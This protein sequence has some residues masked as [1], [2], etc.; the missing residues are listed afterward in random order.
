[1]HT[2]PKNILG[3][4]LIWVIS[5]LLIYTTACKSTQDL[6]PKEVVSII[7]PIP[8]IESDDSNSDD[9][10][11][12]M[13]LL[14]Q[15]EAAIANYRA[16]A[17]REF[18]I[19]DTELDLRFDYE[20]QAVMGEAILTITPYAK[21]QSILVLDAKDFEPGSIYFSHDG[22]ETSTNY[23]YDYKQLMIYLP[24]PV[25]LSDTFSI[26]V[27]Y[28]A[29]P[30]RN[31]GSDNLAIT[32]TKGL[33]F[34]DPL[35]TVPGKPTMIWTQGETEYN[36]KWFPT[37]DKPNE[38]FTQTIH[39]TVKDNLTTVSN[40]ELIAQK[41]LAD[42]MRQDTWRMDLPHAPYLA[43]LAIGEFDVVKRDLDGLP[44][45]YYVEKGY[46]AGA[47][48]VFKHTPEMIRY[49]EDL[50]QVKYP[51]PKYDQIV[52]RDF[53]SGAMENTTASIFME[54]LRLTEREAIDSEWDYIIAHELFHQWFGDLVTTESWANLTLN[55]A[56]ANYSEYLWNEHKYGDDLAKL[57]LIVETETYFQEAETKQ[58]DLIRFDYSD[59]EDMFDAHS[60]SKGGV[61]LHMLR[62]YLG[63]ELFF[64]GLNLYLTTHAFQSVEVHDLR[65][66]FEK[67]SGE[68][69][70]WFFNQWFLDKGHPELKVSIDYSIPEN[71]L[72]T[73]E[74]TQDLTLSPL[75]KLPFEISWYEGEERKS[76]RF[77]LEKGFQQFA[78]ENEF[79]LTQAYFD[80]G[81]DLLTK[82]KGEFSS[83]HYVRQFR[84]S[85]LGIARYEALDSLVSRVEEDKL[86][87]LL[88]EGLKD[89]FWSIRE[90]TLNIL[91]SNPE[92]ISEGM[93]ESIYTIAD[94]DEKNSVRAGA[95]DVLGSLNADKYY[96]DLSRY[97]NDSSF[98]IV[99]SALMAMNNVSSERLDPDLFE[100]FESETNYR[101]LVPVAEYYLNEDIQGKGDWFRSKL[102]V[103]S[104]EG[105][106]YF[107]GY[108]SEYF[109]SNPEE[110]AEEAKAYLL[111]Q[112]QNNPQ[113]FVR[114]G[115]FQ[116]LLGFADDETLV[117]Q[118]QEI[119]SKETNSQIKNYFQYFLQSFGD[120]N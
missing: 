48:R 20:Q 113:V 67:V 103:L 36:S 78:L 101:V 33:Y 62:N 82:R 73:V 21:A 14:R 31:S 1:M 43:A 69:L 10:L 109:V 80:E 29:F 99:S 25:S 116:G 41:P 9:S 79:P 112:M 118:L 105:L 104:G 83:D 66:A 47:A 23:R 44:I 114:L 7:E 96:P 42:G 94:K 60:Y 17:T 34:I 38:R 51:W 45:N 32:D 22:E 61:I 117:K 46:G 97:V 6:P 90:L 76:M 119:A 106:Y 12:A 28:T 54:E 108:F 39:L 92:W 87:P 13:Q 55:E 52:V 120:E 65:L 50:L 77:I 53:V 100:R 70:N 4:N 11:K 19:L 16:A 86:K 57:K 63:D 30:E 40:G 15:K 89:P 35:D 71:L 49:F 58:V 111:D 81:K 68:D 2:K 102:S 8:Q 59:P 110:G 37:I 75:Y 56:F 93:E 24:K 98:L 107:L 5:G 26:R 72:I 18:D 84:E 115:A 95:I 3:K 74:Q 85:Q 64:R 91:Q 27:R 88:A